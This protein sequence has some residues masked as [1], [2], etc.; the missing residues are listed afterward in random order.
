MRIFHFQPPGTFASQWNASLCWPVYF[1]NERLDAAPRVPLGEWLQLLPL[2]ALAAYSCAR[3]IREEL[4]ANAFREAVR[5]EM[6]AV[7]RQA[8]AKRL[9]GAAAEAP[10]GGGAQLL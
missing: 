9:L 1:A 8:T 3:A 10:S 4:Q 2:I 5:T 6:A 7:A